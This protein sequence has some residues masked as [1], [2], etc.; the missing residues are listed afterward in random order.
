[1]QNFKF[2]TYILREICT[3]KKNKVRKYIF[4]YVYHYLRAFIFPIS[5]TFISPERYHIQFLTAVKYI[6]LT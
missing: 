4:R 6:S 2:G 1:M 3:F 5:R